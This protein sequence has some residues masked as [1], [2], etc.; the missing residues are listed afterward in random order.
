MPVVMTDKSEKG[1]TM[2]RAVGEPFPDADIRLIMRRL[3]PETAPSSLV[4]PGIRSAFGRSALVWSSAG[5]RVFVAGISNQ[6]QGITVALGFADGSVARTSEY[7]NATIWAEMRAWYN[8]FVQ[9]NI[10]AV[11]RVELHGH[12]AGGAACEALAKMLSHVSLVESI[13]ID[14]YGAPSPCYAGHA[15]TDYRVSRR[16]WMNAEDVV[17]LVPWTTISTGEH[18]GMYVF[19]RATGAT[20]EQ[21][22]NPSRFTQP[23]IGYRME[24]YGVVPGQNPR[25]HGDP[26][27]RMEAW[28]A[29]DQAAN[30]AHSIEHYLA[31][32]RAWGREFPAGVPIREVHP[33]PDRSG[34]VNVEFAAPL[35]QPTQTEQVVAVPTRIRLDS[36]ALNSLSQVVG[37]AIVGV[38]DM[39]FLKVNPKRAFRLVRVGNFWNV[40][41]GNQIVIECDEPKTPRTICR[42]LNSVLRG[43]GTQNAVNIDALVDGLRTWLDSASQDT[44]TCNPVLRIVT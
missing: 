15:A 20:Q 33:L 18:I 16:R 34:P 12:S 23:N 44:A 17:P 6:R 22:A 29:G 25:V 39:S 3:Y 41:I 21:A 27:T 28:I 14:T 5:L 26:L 19:G 40:S 37:R 10:D 36:I 8:R 11:S 42:R 24:S 35:R 43:F 13:N 9:P 31:K 38:P 1:L 7:F 4:L 2:I 32:F 30:N